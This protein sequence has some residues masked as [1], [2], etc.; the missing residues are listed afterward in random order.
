MRRVEVVPSPEQQDLLNRSVVAESVKPIKFGR[1]V[2]VELRDKALQIRFMP[3]FFDKITSY[4]GVSWKTSRRVWLEVMG[5]PIHVWSEDIFDRIAKG[6][7]R[8]LVM[9][10]ELTKDRA[11]FTVARIL[12]D[13]FQW[14][15]IHEWISV[16]CQD[17]V[18]QVY[19][20]EIG[21]DFLSFQVHPEEDPKPTCSC[22]GCDLPG[23]MEVENIPSETNKQEDS[24][25]TRRTIDDRCWEEIIKETQLKLREGPFEGATH[26]NHSTSKKSLP[27]R[28]EDFKQRKIGMDAETKSDMEKSPIDNEENEETDD[29]E[30]DAEESLTCDDEEDEEIEEAKKTLQVCEDAGITINEDEDVVLEKTTKKKKNNRKRRLK[31]MQLQDGLKLSK[32]L[33]MPGTS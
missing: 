5:L 3:D 15:P 29:I 10:H 11:S 23:T 18:I 7:D 13:C 14:E 6:I 26:D 32:R 20:K 21:A 27:P 24:M 9:Q 1:V 19:F 30:E 2:Q 31:K 33:L 8:C 16:T 4:W 17:A 25:S 12:I 28:F 22:S